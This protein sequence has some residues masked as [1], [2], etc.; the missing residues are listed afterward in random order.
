MTTISKFLQQ[1]HAHCDALFALAEACVERHDWEGAERSY[2]QFDAAL[3]QHLDMEEEVLF[4]AFEGVPGA[5]AGPTAV[6][7]AEHDQL[8]G[9]LSE[10]DD[11]LATRNTDDFLANAETLRIMLGQHNMKEEGILYP[12]A[13]RLLAGCRE[14][15]LARMQEA[16][17]ANGAHA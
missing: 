17:A 16:A 15:I 12:L 6:M 3:N 8:Q 7:R 13:D 5:P 1:D 14:E 10:L 2:A 4:P 11:A 9:I